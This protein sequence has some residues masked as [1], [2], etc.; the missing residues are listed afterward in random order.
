[1]LLGK[2]VWKIKRKNDHLLP[3][4][5]F[6]PLAPLPF[7]PLGPPI[8]GPAARLGRSAQQPRQPLPRA[9]ARAQPLTAWPHLSA[10]PP[11]PRSPRAGQVAKPQPSPTNGVVGAPPPR[12]SAA[13]NSSQTPPR[14]PGCP[15][16]SFSRL[17]STEEG[18]SHR[19][20][21]SPSSNDRPSAR[22]ASSEPPPTPFPPW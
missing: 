16:L 7:S 1:M 3:F 14:A 17:P 21:P 4:L 22:T 20:E 13:S 10:P 9:C 5:K 12:A 8:A 11:T 19:P 18:R 6:G 2:I 15:P